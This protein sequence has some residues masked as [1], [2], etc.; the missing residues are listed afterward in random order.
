LIEV[1]NVKK[2]IVSGCNCLTIVPPRSLAKRKKIDEVKP[3][4]GLDIEGLLLRGKTSAENSAPPESKRQKLT[5]EIGFDDPAKDFKKLIDNEE[6]SWKPGS[7][8]SNKCYLSYSLQRN[9]ESN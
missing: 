8:P 9:G 5:G 1:F 4:S 7:L 6:N 2:G 3:V